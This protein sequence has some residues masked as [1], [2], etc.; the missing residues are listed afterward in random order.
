MNQISSKKANLVAL[1]AAAFGIGVAA[2]AG[3][4]AKS[5]NDSNEVP[6]SGKTGSSETGC[7]AH[8]DG[9]CGAKNEMKKDEVTTTSAPSNA[10]MSAMAPASATGPSATP[11]MAS[12]SAA[13]TTP[14]APP[15]KAVKAGG[16]DSGCGAGSCNT[17]K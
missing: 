16:G 17:K 4:G 5:A 14:K 6:T 8:H 7:G 2:C 13:K 3:P 1:A 9:G 10:T 15:K 11:A 12:A